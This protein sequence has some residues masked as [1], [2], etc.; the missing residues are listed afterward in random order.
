LNIIFDLGGVV[1]RWEPEAIISRVFSDPAVR[2]VVLAEFVG[3]ADWLA[4]DRGTL[5]PR[6]AIARAAKRIG[7]SEAEIGEF[8]RQ[9]PPALVPMAETL[10]LL[11][12]LRAK[13]HILFC[14]SNMAI[15][16]IEYLE[17][18]Y[19]FWEVFEGV[20][21]SCR[22]QLCKPEPAIYTYVLETYAL[23][24]SDTLFIDDTEVNLTT[25]AQLGMHAVRF[26][27]PAQCE[28]ELKLRGCL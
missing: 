1:V 8:L 2:T 16:S 3:H 22:L 17:N 24:P 26:E 27:S 14:L 21:V 20:V 10:E 7:L 9:V 19:T 11:Y 23:D 28:R 13:G 15:A 25:A 6:D 12:R 18:A 4:L 5:S